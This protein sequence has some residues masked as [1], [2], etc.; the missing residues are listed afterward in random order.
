MISKI[1]STA[2]ASSFI[3][4]SANAVLIFGLGSDSRLY[5]FDSATPGAVTNIGLTSGLVDID[6]HAVNRTL[7]GVS[8]TGLASTINLAN[9]AQTLVTTPL[10]ALTGVTAMDFNPFVD[11]IRLAGTGNNNNRL[12]P[13]VQSPTLQQP[14]GTVSVDGNFT[15]AG[16]NVLGV[17]YTNPIDGTAS[18]SL[19]SLGSNGFLHIHSV[20]PQFNTLT[21]VGA[22]LGFTPVGSGFDID[23]LNNGY[24]YDGTNL[25]LVNLATGVGTSQGA[26]GLPGG[27][28]LI[29]LAVIPEPASAML[30]GL[31]ALGM[32]GIR[33][34]RN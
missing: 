3:A 25:R 9:G 23:L 31:G 33:R 6:A 2:I 5:A 11:R 19:Y 1:I 32:L 24:A 28:S 14:N 7:Y 15:T 4:S 29:G 18:T 8:S 26:I 21:Q 12:T 13:D 27:V 34:R 17:A 30:T 16:F 20:S 10:T 22:G